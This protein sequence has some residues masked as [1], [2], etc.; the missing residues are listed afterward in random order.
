M[1]DT[2]NE[3]KAEEEY[4]AQLVEQAMQHFDKATETLYE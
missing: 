1:S 2:E 3:A 4:E